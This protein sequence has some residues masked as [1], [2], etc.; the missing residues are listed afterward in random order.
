MTEK[1]A[2]A[3]PN[4][5]GK[6]CA[7][8]VVQDTLAAKTAKQSVPRNHL[9]EAEKVSTLKLLFR[10]VLPKISSIFFFLLHKLMT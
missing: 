10:L 2:V 8:Q 6:D 9:H 5:N 4:P 3:T 1:F 7:K